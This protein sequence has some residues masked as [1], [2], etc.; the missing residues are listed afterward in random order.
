MW[1]LTVLTMALHAQ[2]FHKVRR[3]YF[4]C[5]FLTFVRTVKPILVSLQLSTVVSYD[6]IERTSAKSVR[7]VG[8]MSSFTLILY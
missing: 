4:A 7:Y 2:E 5:L 8:G 1:Y 3:I 6:R